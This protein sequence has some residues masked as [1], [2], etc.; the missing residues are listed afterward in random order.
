MTLL[1]RYIIRQF[2]M[3]LLL[4]LVSLVAIYLLVDFFE[5][6]D[7]FT[8]AGKPISLAF[9]YLLLKIPLIYDQ[10]APVC[11]LLAGV[12]TLGLLQKSRELMS[13]NAGGISL[14]RIV[15]PV[16]VASLLFTLLSL[17]VAQMVLPVSNSRMNEIWYQEVNQQV[18]KGIVRKGRIFHRGERG[19]YAL[20]R[21]DPHLFRFSH[22]TYTEWDETRRNIRLFLTAEVAAWDETA[23]W[24]FANG[25]LK[26]PRPDGGYDIEVF[27]HRAFDL[28]DRPEQ[29][30]I[31]AYRTAELSLLEL[32]NKAR[33]DLDKGMQ[34]GLIDL[35]RRLSFIFLGIP[36][37]MLALPLL[38]A[39]QRQWSRDLAMT[40]P[41]SCVLAFFAW[42][43]WNAGQALSQAGR[44]HPVAA[45]WSIH[46]VLSAT[47]FL[48]LWRANRR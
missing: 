23:G 24:R 39:M 22:F 44:L 13:L 35:N 29:F 41:A 25:Q 43:A 42:A 14:A 2:F 9:T 36:L 46:L 21:P 38:H 4:V 12:V 8:E 48:L 11:I 6:I 40:V 31:P 34:Q 3:N 17:I 1:D 18:A 32:A 26:R 45:S 5:R 15:L 33:A 19:I 37:L 10:M 30:F 27:S 28:P 47:G 16:L 20:K 7:N